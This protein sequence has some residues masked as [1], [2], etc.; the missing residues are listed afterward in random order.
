M[1]GRTD[2]FQR[3]SAVLAQR[4]PVG[5][6]SGL[7]N[8]NPFPLQVVESTVPNVVGLSPANAQQVVVQAGLTFAVAAR[9]TSTTATVAIIAAQNPVA[10]SKV[11]PGTTVDVTEAV[12]G[13]AVPDLTD[14]S[15]IQARQAVAAVGLRLSARGIGVVVAQSPAMGVVVARGS[16]VNVTLS[17]A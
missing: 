10:G 11:D 1:T 2:G 8:D 4:F 7:T 13:V 5:Q 3:F 9:I 16:T 17:N 12:P 6:P 14:L 15:L